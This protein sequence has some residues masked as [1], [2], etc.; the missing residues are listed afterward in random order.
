[1]SSD[2]EAE[3]A[4]RLQGAADSAVPP[5]AADLYAG[6]VQR[7]RRIRR[8]TMVGRT[9]AGV[10]TLGVVAAVGIPLL[11]GAT[12]A[13]GATGSTGSTGS[14]TAS[15]GAAA[16]TTVKAAAT[17]GVRSTDTAAAKPVGTAGI[18]AYMASTLRSLLPAGSD[19]SVKDDVD[20]TTIRA[21]GPWLGMAGGNW[22]GLVQTGL[23]TGSGTSS[24]ELATLATTGTFRCP[25]RAQAP[26]D[27]CT[28]T[29]VDGATLV[30]DQS[31]KDPV[32][33]E[34][35]TIWDVYWYRPTGG[36][37]HLDEVTDAPHRATRPAP[38]ALTA[39]QMVTIATDPAW[40]RVW[41]ALPPPCAYGVMVGKP[42][43]PT[44]P[45]NGQGLVCATSRAAALPL[46]GSSDGISVEG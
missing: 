9:L 44:P 30:V 34:G 25:T 33:G 16:P 43:T 21:Y 18:P 31:F 1:M 36:S 6:A 45:W 15:V 17:P 32:N 3:F 27:Q 38:Q 8:R 20:D 41:E 40:T 29:T 26:Y 4:Q 5:A 42:T 10:A 24:V 28:S 19:A 12:G 23:A 22:G 35:A 13:T 39:Q 37:V 2:F 46:Y 14:A 11:G 7:G